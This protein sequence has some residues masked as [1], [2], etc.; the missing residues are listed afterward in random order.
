MYHLQVSYRY[1]DPKMVEK[2]LE[3]RM[4]IVE[5]F[6]QK[7]SFKLST[8]EIIVIHFTKQHAHLY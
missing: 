8:N 5:N 7:N 4:N 2:K 6:P 3:E 1:P